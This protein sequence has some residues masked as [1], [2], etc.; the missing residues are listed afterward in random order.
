[1]ECTLPPAG[2]V[3]HFHLKVIL[4]LHNLLCPAQLG[5]SHLSGH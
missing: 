3:A 2:Q 1:M 5:I 4:Q